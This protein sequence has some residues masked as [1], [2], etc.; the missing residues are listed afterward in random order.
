MKVYS[1]PVA[2]L[3]TVVPGIPGPAEAALGGD[4]RGTCHDLS[5]LTL[6]GFTLAHGTSVTCLTDSAD[7]SSSKPPETVG[8]GDT[9][10]NKSFLKKKQN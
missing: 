8:D 1:Q 7:R 10:E 3:S 4:F 5:L 9:E 2:G 6:P